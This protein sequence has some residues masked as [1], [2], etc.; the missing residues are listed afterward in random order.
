M[1]I[2]IEKEGILT[3]IQDTGR[4]GFRHLGINPNGA[5]D[6]AAA[7]LINLLLGNYE[8]EAV[9][10][11]HFP[12]PWIVFERSAVFALGGANFNAE[13]NGEPV[14]NW[15]PFY[16][17]RGSRLKFTGK[18]FGN[19]AYL[20]VQGGFKIEKWLGSAST[21]LTAKTGGVSGGKL[22]KNDS[23]FFNSETGS[24]PKRFHYKVS[25]SL[26][27]FYSRF[28]TVRIIAGGE[29]ELLTAAGEL[30]LSRQDFV[31]SQ[32]SDRM[33]FRLQGEPLFL[34]DKKELVSSAVDF[35]TIQLLPDGQ[36]IILMADHQ[37]S[38]GYPRLAHVVKQDLPLIA[39]LGAN[40]KIAFHLISL[41]EAEDIQMQFE[42][43]LRLLRI[44]VKYSP[45]I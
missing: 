36:L 42:K 33:G 11:M 28:P 9:L 15:K 8:S 38:G 10:E 27:P 21:N 3:T 19:R 41:E 31:V 20:T 37:T 45:N 35:G 13:L 22:L 6:L 26:I 4:I 1:S 5:M 16:A 32:N 2:T 24:A 30:L 12:A 40:D 43:D 44:A 17:E 7:R 25:G 23:L 18:S 39:Q 34:I 14:E 29:H